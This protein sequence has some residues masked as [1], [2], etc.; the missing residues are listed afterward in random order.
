MEARQGVL[1]G[2]GTVRTN[3]SWNQESTGHPWKTGVVLVG[4][5]WVQDTNHVSY[6][7]WAVPVCMVP[8]HIR[9]CS[10]PACLFVL[11]LPRLEGHVAG[12]LAFHES[13]WAQ[14]QVPNFSGWSLGMCIL[15]RYRGDFEAS[16]QLRVSA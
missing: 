1:P 9:P 16:S 15:Q 4:R 11:C 8:A 2:R 12:S 10:R 5:G 3:K 14:P 6:L 13:S 7:G